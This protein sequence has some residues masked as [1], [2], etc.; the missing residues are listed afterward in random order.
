MLNLGIVGN[1]QLDNVKVTTRGRQHERRLLV[2]AGSQLA[3]NVGTV[4]QQ[5]LNHTLQRHFYTDFL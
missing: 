4:A 1:Q 2:S 5:H 3:V